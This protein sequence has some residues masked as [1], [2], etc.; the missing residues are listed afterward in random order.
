[1][2][3]NNF[4]LG[5]RSRQAVLTIHI[6]VAVAWIGVNLAFLALDAVALTTADGRLV[7]ACISAIV[8]I[9]PPVVPALVVGMMI[10]GVVLGLG[11]K[12][13]LFRHWW[14]TSKLIIGTVLLVL[15]AV[16]LIPNALSMATPDPNRSADQLR[17]QFDMISLLMPPI[18]S[19]VA[20]VAA[21][22][23]SVYKP[24]GLVRQPSTRV[25]VS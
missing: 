18:V 3:S 5:K 13:G 19:S 10:S 24:A 8:I 16:L 21:T 23:L 4:Q 25:A 15:V 9:I 11:T 22:V 20:L 7:A 2:V 12:W 14:V 1:M 17:D 6:V